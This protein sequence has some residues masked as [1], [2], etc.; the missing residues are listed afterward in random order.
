MT[1]RG[2]E[3]RVL[4]FDGVF[5]TSWYAIVTDKAGKETE[6]GLHRLKLFAWISAFWIALH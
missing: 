2:K 3:L 4:P 1:F 6:G 5:G